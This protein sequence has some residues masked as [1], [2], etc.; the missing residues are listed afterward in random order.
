MQLFK[1]K[2]KKVFWGD[3]VEYAVSDSLSLLMVNYKFG[4]I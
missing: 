1:K 3:N 2:K 4:F